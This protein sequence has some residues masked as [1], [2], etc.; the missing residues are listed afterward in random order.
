MD[1]MVAGPHGVRPIQAALLLT[2]ENIA[3][4]LQ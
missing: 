1:A 4:P 3:V 2:L